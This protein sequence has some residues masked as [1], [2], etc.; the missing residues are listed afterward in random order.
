MCICTRLP[1]VYPLNTIENNATVVLIITIVVFIVCQTP[2]PI[3]QLLEV[4]A[5]SV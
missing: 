4:I 2:E 1:V 5:R 3:L